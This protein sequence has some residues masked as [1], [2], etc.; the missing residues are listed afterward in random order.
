MMLH[1]L[2]VRLIQF[3]DPAMFFQELYAAARPARRAAEGVK[4][5]HQAEA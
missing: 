3:I 5:K 2:Q 1:A 4:L